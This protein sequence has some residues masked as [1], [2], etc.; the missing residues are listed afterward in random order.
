[1][2]TVATAAIVAIAFLNVAAAPHVASYDEVSLAE[3]FAVTVEIDGATEGGFVAGYPGRASISVVDGEV[4]FTMGGE[5]AIAGIY[6]DAVSVSAPLGAGPATVTATYDASG[7]MALTVEQA[8]ASQMVVGAYDPASLEQLSMLEGLVGGVACST[9]FYVGEA[10]AACLVQPF[11]GVISD[12]TVS[13]T[14]PADR[15]A[16]R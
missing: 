6:R 1:M 13:N 10:D 14:T 5:E 12:L 2:N 4:V 15:V 7:A 8:S 3:L 11:D 9:N 16:A